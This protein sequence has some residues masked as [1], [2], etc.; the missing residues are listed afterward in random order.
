MSLQ[1]Q[2]LY[3]RLGIVLLRLVNCVCLLF[4]FMMYVSLSV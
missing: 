2:T 4:D 1:E 3:N